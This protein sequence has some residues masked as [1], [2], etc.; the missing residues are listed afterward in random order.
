MLHLGWLGLG[1][2]VYSEKY[3]VWCEVVKCSESPS[4][5]VKTPRGKSIKITEDNKHQFKSEG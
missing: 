3:Q 4:V 1:E 2:Q 5:T